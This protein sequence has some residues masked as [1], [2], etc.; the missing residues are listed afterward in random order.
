MHVIADVVG[1][2]TDTAPSGHFTAIVPE[3]LVDSRDGTGGFN[4][5]WGPGQTRNVTVNSVGPIPDNAT[6]VVLNVTGIFPT[7]ATHL[8][9]WPQG[10]TRPN[11][12]NLNLQPGDVLPNAVVVKVSELGQISV[13]NNAGSVDV[14]V[15]VVGYYT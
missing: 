15:D 5:P 8:T 2:C 9:I 12:S 4:T 3:R 1:Y 13:F 7:Q 10:L 14:V 6:A 11:A